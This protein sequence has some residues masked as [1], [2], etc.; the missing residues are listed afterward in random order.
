MGIRMF[1]IHLDNHPVCRKVWNSWSTMSQAMGQLLGTQGWPGQT[2]SPS[3]QGLEPS[4]A[5]K[6]VTRCS[7]GCQLSTKPV[8]LPTIFQGTRQ[9]E[10]FLVSSA[11]RWSHTWECWP[12][13]TWAEA[14]CATARGNSW[15]IAGVHFFAIWFLP[16]GYS[17]WQSH[18]PPRSMG[19]WPMVRTIYWPRHVPSEQL[20]RSCYSNPTNA[21]NNYNKDYD[22]NSIRC[23]GSTDGDVRRQ[24]GRASRLFI[25]SFIQQIFPERLL[26]TRHCSGCN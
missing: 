25:C 23:W 15:H 16:P 4:E 8:L 18:C 12:I 20:L 19:L 6:Q 1:Q 24:S 14:I 3:S 9:T 11:D 17:G 26:C 7:H 21:L 5:F 2:Y 10:V 13:S 22:S